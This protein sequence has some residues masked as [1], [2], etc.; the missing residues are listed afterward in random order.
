MLC[1]KVTELRE[2]PICTPHSAIK[3]IGLDVSWESSDER[4]LIECVSIIAFEYLRKV[5]KS[6]SKFK[7]TSDDNKHS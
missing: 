5:V 3:L 1:A 6:L 4:A 7:A 2:L